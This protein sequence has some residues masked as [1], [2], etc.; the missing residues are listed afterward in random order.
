[1]C[2]NLRKLS[3][4]IVN[5]YD[6]FP[7]VSQHNAKIITIV[8]KFVKIISGEMIEMAV[9]NTKSKSTQIVRNR[10]CGRCGYLNAATYLACQ[11][12]D[13]ALSG[14]HW[15]EVEVQ[16]EPEM[17]KVSIHE[18]PT[19]KLKDGRKAK[20]EDVIP[21]ARS[22]QMKAPIQNGGE[23]SRRTG[24]IHKRNTG[25]LVRDHIFDDDQT[26]ITDAKNGQENGTSMI[27]T[28]ETHA[29]R[30]PRHQVKAGTAVFEVGMVI[31]I[32]IDG[33]H[34][35]IVLRPSQKQPL[36]FGRD[37]AKSKQRPDID[38]VPYGGFQNGI[39]RIHASLELAGKRMTICDKG[40]SNGTFLNDAKL[41][42][43]EKHQIRDGDILRLG[44]M[45]LKI[46]F[47]Q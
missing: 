37:D 7:A 23:S 31:C 34:T 18:M 17:P 5:I 39:S 22:T 16:Q 6:K 29:V 1:M 45:K 27:S 13:H 41:D 4:K 33:K 20:L 30:Q 36:T 38:L 47:K 25:V 15:V 14:G 28:V 32:E 2:L 9:Q 12:C 24:F 19:S 10:L 11:H 42:A 21:E 35:P 44:Q 46:S 8:T 40:S 26:L 43:N 3:P